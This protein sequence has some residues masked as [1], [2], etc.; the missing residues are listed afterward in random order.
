MPDDR[1]KKD[2]P[3]EFTQQRLDVR[4]AYGRQLQIGDEVYVVTRGPILLRVA[5]I[6]PT[7]DPAAPPDVLYVHLGV[8]VPF[9]AR[10]GAVNK[11]FIRTRTVQEAGPAP[12]T[13]VGVRGDA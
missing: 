1:S 7:L 13:L 12:F 3:P 11:E 10:R 9:A 8:M 4:D 2:L 6:T 5:E